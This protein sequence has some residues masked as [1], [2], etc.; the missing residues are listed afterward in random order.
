MIRKKSQ[1]LGT[2]SQANDFYFNIIEWYSQGDT[3]QHHAQ[4]VIRPTQSDIETKA[5]K[6][7]IGKKSFKCKD[8][9]ES[10]IQSSQCKSHERI[11]TNGKPHKCQ[12]CDKRFIKPFK[13]RI[14]ERT[15]TGEKPY[16]CKY[17]EKCFTTSANCKSHERVH[18]GVKPY[19][20]KYCGKCF[21]FFFKLPDA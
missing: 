8:C 9:N 14:H 3:M 15:H 2:S 13:L 12:Y 4:T 7:S 21:A 20:C 19:Q 10:F 11:H 18:T 1:K 6:G 17:C 16:E 5:T